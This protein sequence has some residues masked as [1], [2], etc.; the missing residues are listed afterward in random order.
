[1]KTKRAAAITL[2]IPQNPLSEILGMLQSFADDGRNTG[3]DFISK[4]KS[5]FNNRNSKNRIKDFLP[6]IILGVVGFTALFFVGRFIISAFEG[7]TLGSSDS[8]VELKGPRAKMSLDKTYEFPLTDDKGKEIARL[9]FFVDD[10]ELRD[11]IILGGQKAVAPK[12]TTYLI[13]T[14]KLTNT[15]N[16][17]IEMRVRNYVRLNING[18]KDEWQAA[19]I[20]NDPVEVQPQSTKLTRL[21]FPI[22]DADKDL[23]LRIGD[24]EGKKETIKLDLTN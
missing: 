1:M 11:E 4:I 22:N 17:F 12:G 19:S 23:M 7:K 9:K 20:H 10:A 16:K 8:R 15:S 2:T 6:L 14:I 18:N 5:Q 3:T 24:L 21:G 13:T